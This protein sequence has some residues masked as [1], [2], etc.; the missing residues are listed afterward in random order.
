[1]SEQTLEKRTITIEKVGPYGV[2]VGGV[3]YGLN[4][5]VTP[6]DFAESKTYQ[7][8]MKES[9]GKYYIVSV[10]REVF[11][12]AFERASA[13]NKETTFPAPVTTSSYEVEQDKKSN[14]ILRQGITQAVAS[15]LLVN[16]EL[17]DELLNQV[18]QYSERLIKFVEK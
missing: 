11:Q 5:P 8:E 10:L 13:A 12:F 1:M 18:E 14:R 7:V 9:K 4:R 15:A 16:R 17:N 3:W 6:K 2:K